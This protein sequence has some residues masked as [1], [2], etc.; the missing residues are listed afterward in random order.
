MPDDTGRGAASGGTPPAGASGHDR[1]DRSDPTLRATLWAVAIA[2]VVLT[3]G[4]TAG[5]D[6]R[7]AIGVATGGAIAVAN[8]AVFIRVGRAFL[9]KKN[10]APWGAVA[11]VKLLALVGGVWLLLKN[12]LVSPLALAAGYGALPIGITLGVLFGPKPPED[13][14]PP[15]AP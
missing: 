14:A 8:L 9:E 13:P 7:A 2:A 4:A 15:P 11:V 3:A 10:T 1:T 5:F 12:G 6:R